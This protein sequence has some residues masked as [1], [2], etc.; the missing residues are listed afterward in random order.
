MVKY[1]KKKRVIK[2]A[3]RKT[4]TKINLTS[5]K[6]IVNRAIARNTENKTFEVYNTGTLIYGSSNAAMSSTIVPVSP[7]AGY[8]QINQGVSQGDR[9]G[10]R[11]K[12]KKI[13]F[14]GN[15]I[16]RAYNNI[17]NPLPCP[18]MVIIRLF[19]DRVNPMIIPNASSSDFLQLGG[20]SR[21]LTNDL[22]DVYAPINNDRFRL[23]AK[24]TFKVGFA[25]YESPIVGNRYG[26]T[27][28]DYKLTANFK[29]DI[30]KHCIQEVK[31]ND[32]SSSPNTRGVFAVFQAVRADG[33]PIPSA[34]IMAE[35][36][37]ILRMDYE[38]A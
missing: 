6:S 5:V 13:T 29:F 36:S 25:A 32:N 21:G 28:N 34:E 8:L 7:Y 11:I 24:K 33:S 20:S 9:I 30:T 12:I 2:K 10:N 17:T 16:P 14:K 31:Y 37:Y 19:Y 15:I 38:D 35:Y 27:N 18:I 22:V 1:F 26:N 4:K 23:L 3:V